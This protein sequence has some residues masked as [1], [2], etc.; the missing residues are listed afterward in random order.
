M[1]D[2]KLFNIPPEAQQ[3][4]AIIGAGAMGVSIASI[5]SQLGMAKVTLLE[6]ES[7]PLNHYSASFNNTGILHHFVYGGHFS[8]L[9]LLFKQ[10]LLF[11]KV[12]PDCVFEDE[13]VNYLVPNIKGNTAIDREG[14]TI[15]DV[16]KNLIV[17]YRNH[18]NNYPSYQIFGSVQELVQ[19]IDIE[20]ILW[21]TGDKN[22]FNGAV[23]V[24]QPV[25]NIDKYCNHLIQL[26][27]QLIKEEKI[28][29]K[30]NHKVTN[31]EL[32]NQG[33]ELNI[34]HEKSLY[35]NTVI[36]TGYA[37]GLEI[38]IPSFSGEKEAG[39]IVKLKAYGIY[40]I[41]ETLK[42]KIP[43]LIE[44]FS[45]TLLIRGQYAGIIKTGGDNLAIF[46]GL[47]YNQAE[48]YVPLTQTPINLPKNWI[49]WIK[50][51]TD[52]FGNRNEASI[53]QAIQQ[54]VS[55]WIPW[56]AELE[57]IELKKNLQV[58]PG[59]EPA[60]ELET[61]KRDH[62]PIRYQYQHQTGEQYI[63]IP[64]AKL[65]SVIYHSFLII[66]KLLQTY[67]NKQILTEQEVNKHLIIDN[68]RTIIISPE[69]E[70]L[71]GKKLS[72]SSP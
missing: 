68:N 40:K 65:T 32:S 55:Q 15:K 52:Y 47:E 17:I 71:L 51:E 69:L 60:N 16:S 8:T 22:F 48:F 63:H 34:N 62:N 23:K 59:Q 7:T 50:G 25:L 3:E 56:V 19:E 39:N 38:P 49:S 1:S 64:G 66:D 26:L 45:S 21:G 28:N 14:V 18:I 35:F 33:F 12:M 43:Q 42:T 70:F 29:L 37:E 58:Y 41:P 2:K 27:N 36:N 11:K 30:T 46:Y 67:I 31:V 9:E 54:G 61:A 72:Q 57:P 5:L 44:G 10:T 6:A 53:L 13:Y 24:K 4:I 20:E